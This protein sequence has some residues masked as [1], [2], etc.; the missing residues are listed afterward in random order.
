MVEY[1]STDGSFANNIKYGTELNNYKTIGLEQK[2]SFLLT[3]SHSGRDALNM[4]ERLQAYRRSLLSR[5]RIVT[6]EDLKSVCFEFFGDKIEN[7][8]IKNSYTIDLSLNKGMINCIDIELTVN[9]SKEIDEVEWDFVKNNLLLFLE[10]HAT[11]VFPF[12]IKKV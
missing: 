3:S 8:D 12:V 11:S 6:K 4:D 5:D 10:K 1:W 9:K 2:S 7:V